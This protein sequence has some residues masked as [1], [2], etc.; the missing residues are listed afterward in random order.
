MTSI[1]MTYAYIGLAMTG[2]AYSCGGWTGGDIG[3]VGVA[4]VAAYNDKAMI[5]TVRGSGSDIWGGAD[6]FHYVHRLLD[7]DGFIIARVESISQTDP[8]SKCGVMIRETMDPGA[9]FAGICV[10]PSYGLCFQIRAVENDAV[11]S[12]TAVATKAQ[13]AE[14]APVWIKLERKRDQLYGYYAT[15]KAGTQWTPMAW[16]PQQITLPRVVVT[17]RRGTSVP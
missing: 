1:L 11:K 5:W 13:Q 6:A 15:D 8:W 7:G 9:R 4:G 2:G 10:T 3:N 17:V 14:K 16:T 12:D